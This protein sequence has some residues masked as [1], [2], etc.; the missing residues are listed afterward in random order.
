MSDEK[1]KAAAK[2][3]KTAFDEY[4]TSTEAEEDGAWVE[5]RAGV[6]VKIRSENSSEVRE[7]L[8]KLTKTQR[9]ILKAN[10]WVLPPKLQDRNDVLACKNAIVTDWEGVTDR[11]GN[12][13]P[14]SPDNVERILTALPRLREEILFI[15]KTDETYKAAKEDMLGNS[16]ASS[17]DSSS[18]ADAATT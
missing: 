3:P 2:K 13:V 14:Y 11:E 17:R 18:S 8:T 10:G 1:T 15:A 12:P 9:N 4:E 16:A 5:F 7:Y 6:K